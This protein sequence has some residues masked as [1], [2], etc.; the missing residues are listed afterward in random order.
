MLPKRRKPDSPKYD[1]IHRAVLTGLLAN[2]GQKT[3]PHEY[4][5]A[6]G[7]KFYIFPGSSLFAQGPQ[8]LV[9]A[10]LVETT[11]LYARTVAKIQPEWTERIAEHLV[12]RTYTDP[13]WNPDTA[14]VVAYE[15]VTLYGLTIIPQRTVHYGPIDPK[16]SREIFIHA[17][18]EGEYRTDAPF[19]RHN[20]RLIDE[21]QTL[22]AKSRQRDVLVDNQARYDFYGAHIPAGI[23]NGPLFERWRRQI[24]RHN[25]KALFMSRRDLMMHGAAG[26]TQEQFPDFL[27]INEL[28]LPLE[29]HLEPGHP[30][31]GVTV[32]VP[33]ALLNQVPAERFEWL[34]PGLF[35][36]KITA[37]IKSLPKNLRVNFVPAPDHAQAAY[38]TLK[39][40]DGSLLDA[41]AMFLGK[42]SGIK[43]PP[44]AF[45]PSTLLDH[46]HMN[47][48]IV[49][50]AGKQLAMGRD[51]NELRRK[52]GVQVKTTFAQLPHPK[53]QREGITQ[54]DFGDLPESVA[55]KRH[56]MTLTAYPAL[57]DNQ[58][59]VA[60]RLMDSLEA[61]HAAHAAGLR[62]L[63][64]LQLSDEVRYLSTHIPN[65]PEM[66]LHY[67]T[68]GPAKDLKD[69]IV[70]ETINR[71]F[72]PDTNV[73]TQMEVELRLA[74]GRRHRLLEVAADVADL[75]ARILAA[76][77][78]VALLLGRPVI[79][80]WQIAI[81]DVRDQLAQLMPKGFLT[82]TPD[83]WLVQ[84]PR[85]LKAIQTR[86]AKLT[87][88]GHTR[89]AQHLAE[90]APL[91]QAYVA[92]AKRSREE[93]VIDANLEHFRWMIE[94]LRVSL[95]AQEL[96][97]SIPVS[98]KRLEKQWELVR[99]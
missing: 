8:W 90:I 32:T 96:K 58:T 56:G 44:E 6:R 75:A 17:M 5:G 18:I 12:K 42:Q 93:G 24:E 3:D 57:V 36:E 84:F 55:V 94:E 82:T 33:L 19:V 71:T 86:L 10:E 95:F 20:Q 21:I 22:E 91:W 13:H 30:A 80:A 35:L 48:R 68:L 88:A 72:L 59:S 69:D 65:L 76:Y 25:P 53:Y 38:E 92:Q 79:P 62:R 77:H 7:T 11:R 27:L 39:P 14:H 85:F 52:L 29:Y 99:K 51:L 45:D 15:K 74:A 50:E 2:I 60:L 46:L 87:T 34:V 1:A 41:L 49:D 4:T 54:W 81:D 83:S 61:A 26:I 78:A 40:G 37:L 16:T 47:Y 23:Y 28:R 43:V 31:D 70:G 67:A 63:F 98:A 9:A 66:S 89:D 73:R 64:L 97:T